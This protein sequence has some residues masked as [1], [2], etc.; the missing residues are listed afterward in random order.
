MNIKLI[1]FDLGNVVFQIHWDWVVEA[2]A[3][4]AGANPKDLIPK[5]K[6]DETFYKFEGG[7]ISEEEF[8]Q[9]VINKLGINI[10]FNEFETG[11]NSIYGDIIEE[12]RESIEY[13]YKKIPL[14]AFTNTNSIHNK[15]WPERY[16]EVLKYFDKI[17]ISSDLKIKK[18]DKEAFLYVLRDS[19]VEPG[20]VLFFDDLEA[21]VLSAR[22]LGMHAVRVDSGKSVVDGLSQL[23][24]K[25]G[26]WLLVS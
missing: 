21:N 17:Y 6:H 1:I 20:E 13:L 11:W 15:I 14:V 8:Y 4:F 7:E 10:S 12:T 9:H 24:E 26:N 19:K 16:K 18:P 25:G 22:S 3:R 5:F 23:K 2:W